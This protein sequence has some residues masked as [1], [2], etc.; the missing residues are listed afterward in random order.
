M[1]YDLGEL[2]TYLTEIAESYGSAAALWDNGEGVLCS[3]A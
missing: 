1:A 2:G 3:L